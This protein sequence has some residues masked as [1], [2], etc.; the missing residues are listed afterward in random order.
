[1]WPDLQHYVAQ[2]A[3]L[4]APGALA[5]D[6][7]AWIEEGVQCAADGVCE[8]DGADGADG[9]SRGLA[10]CTKH[11]SGAELAGCAAYACMRSACAVRAQCMRSACAVHSTT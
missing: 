11:F 3:T 5:P 9:E 4:C 7:A 6:A 10:A 1:M 2:P 8:V